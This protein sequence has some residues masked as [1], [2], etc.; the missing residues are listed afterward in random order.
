MNNDNGQKIS[1]R[2]YKGRKLSGKIVETEAYIG[3]KD[4]DFVSKI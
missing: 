2:I 3:P 4:N 1:S